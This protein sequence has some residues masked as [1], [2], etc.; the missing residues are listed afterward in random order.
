MNCLY[1]KTN[2]YEMR[3]VERLQTKVQSSELGK[4]SLKQKDFLAFLIMFAVQKL[5]NS[6]E[7]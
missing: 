2:S 4:Q 3:N 5:N 1:N 7:L 6:T